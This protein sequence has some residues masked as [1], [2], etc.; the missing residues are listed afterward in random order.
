MQTRE[1]D[2]LLFL[3]NIFSNCCRSMPDVERN[4]YTV[5]LN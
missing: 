3:A 2:D 1:M 4:A 5:L